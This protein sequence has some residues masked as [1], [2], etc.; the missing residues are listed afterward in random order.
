MKVIKTKIKIVFFIVINIL[1]SSS[2]N[3]QNKIVNMRDLKKTNW[4]AL[5]ENA[6]KLIGKDWMLITAGKI[7]DYNMMTA[8]WGA[9]GWLWEKPVSFIFVRPQRYTHKFTEREDYYTLCF[10]DENNREILSKMGTVSGRNFDKMNYEQLTAIE[11]DNG[12]VAFAEARII[13]EC[14]KLYATKIK[15]DDF[16]DEKIP[17]KVYPTRD[18]HTMYVGE[19][20]NVWIRE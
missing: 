13:I 1:I 7:N 6:V 14:K 19:I 5:N 8:S 11:T 9:L 16:V 12:S 4:E 18:F 20:L 3:S 10:F 17:A 2:C 15:E